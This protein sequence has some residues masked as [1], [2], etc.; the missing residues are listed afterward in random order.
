[1]AEVLRDLLRRTDLED[2]PSP[3]VETLMLAAGRSQHLDKLIRPA[4]AEGKVVISE[5]FYQSTIAYQHYGRGL[6]FDVIRATTNFAIGSFEADVVIVLD[7]PAEVGL[8][9]KY[10]DRDSGGE[11]LDRFELEKVEFHERVRSGYL[12]MVEEYGYTLVDATRSIPEVAEDVLKLTLEV[13][14]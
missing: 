9:R 2:V 12:N 13:L 6:G 4:L 3:K 7:V 11:A 5:R 14:V 10:R 1:L 8:Q